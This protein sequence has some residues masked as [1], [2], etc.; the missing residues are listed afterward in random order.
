MILSE[1][2]F[3]QDPVRGRPGT[4]STCIGLGRCFTSKPG[5]KQP[6]G[7]LHRK[8]LDAGSSVHANQNRGREACSNIMPHGPR[9]AR[10]H[11]RLS[12]LGLRT[13]GNIRCAA[14]GRALRAFQVRYRSLAN[15]V[16]S[17]RES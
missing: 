1:C 17:P 7:M 12:E 2:E 15:E 9:F 5:K 11:K 14:L 3:Y 6:I 4:G 13:I 16:P 10:A 8:Q